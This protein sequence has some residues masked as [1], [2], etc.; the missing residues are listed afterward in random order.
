MTTSQRPA[1][2][3]S[4]RAI[5]NHRNALKSTGPKTQSGKLRSS[6]NAVRHGY[7]TPPSPSSTLKHLRFILSDP[8]A[9]VASSLATEIG[10]AA[11]ALAVAEA[12]LDRILEDRSALQVID[13]DH[14]I[15]AGRL[16]EALPPHRSRNKE[17]TW[18]KEAITFLLKQNHRSR[19]MFKIQLTQHDRYLAH[20]HA[21]RRKALI[22]YL[23]ATD[24]NLQNEA[25]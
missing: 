13:K 17:E 4:K 12:R 10:Q 14:E 19:K 6:T 9:D 11:L 16:F 18:M 21:T 25:K 1:R 23:A 2:A 5:S 3:L 7:N 15:E 8:E 24:K 20:A 22:R